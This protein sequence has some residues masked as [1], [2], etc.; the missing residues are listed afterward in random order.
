MLTESNAIPVNLSEAHGGCRLWS[1]QPQA[2]ARIAQW[3][4]WESAHCQQVLSGLL[5]AVVGHRLL[6]ER[7]APPTVGVEWDHEPLRPLLATRPFVAGEALSIA[8]FAVAGMTTYFRAGAFPFERRPSFAAG[9]RGSRSSR[10]GARPRI[11][12]GRSESLKLGRGRRGESFP[13]RARRVSVQFLARRTPRFPI[14]IARA[15]ALRAVRSANPTGLSW[16][17]W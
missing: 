10:P 5:A 17:D 4:C 8:A 15:L 7:G 13:H 9:T 6:P 1:Q 12:F 2:R 3:L 14:G 16:A 11:R